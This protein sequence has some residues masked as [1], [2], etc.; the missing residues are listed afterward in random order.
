M[1]ILNRA[2][3]FFFQPLH[4]QTKRNIFLSSLLLVG[5]LFCA[6]TL[7]STEIHSSHDVLSHTCVTYDT[8]GCAN[9][10]EHLTHWQAMSMATL[11]TAFPLVILLLLAGVL[12]FFV[13]KRFLVFAFQK[14]AYSIPIFRFQEL[15]PTL[16]QQLFSQGLLNSKA[17]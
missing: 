11:G 3:R 17:Y 12:V 6:L 16:L 5:I 10:A 13:H 15:P 7:S 4:S 1:T 14:F 2:T 8:G 9:I